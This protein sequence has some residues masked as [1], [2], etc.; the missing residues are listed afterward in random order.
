VARRMGV[1]NRTRPTV[2][3]ARRELAP[4]AV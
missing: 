4:T 3:E 2:A 1:E